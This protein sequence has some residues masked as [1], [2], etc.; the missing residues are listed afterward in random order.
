MSPVVAFDNSGTLSETTVVTEPVAPGYEW[1][2]SVP[3]TP[4][5][6]GTF[7]LVN[8]SVEDPQTLRSDDPLGRALRG[9]DST[10][11]PALTNADVSEDRVEEILFGVE[12]IKARELLEVAERAVEQARTTTEVAID[13]PLSR[14]M[15]VVVNVPEAVVVR[16]VGYTTTPTSAAP[17]VVEAFTDRGWEV[18]I[19]SGDSI[20]VLAP[21]AES[22]GVPVENVH[23]YQS[24]EDKRRTVE[25][26]RSE[27]PVVMVGDFVNDRY[28]FVAA[29]VAV[30]VD[31]G[32]DE[33]RRQIDPVADVT[34][35]GLSEV[36]RTLQDRVPELLEPY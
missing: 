34:V 4:T 20:E 32:R 14:G 24:P 11:R 8:V 9:A 29:D 22:V 10:I 15:Q 6:K 2:E 23:P 36:P 17:R 33:V 1:L 30:F 13:R 12:G 7:A 26:L 16:L 35:E 27:D 21:V 31:N 18:H 5:E 3:T 25:Q 28:A 19:V